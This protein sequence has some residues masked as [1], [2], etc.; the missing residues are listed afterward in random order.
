MKRKVYRCSCFDMSGRYY[1]WEKHSWNS[2]M[3]SL[4]DYVRGVAREGEIWSEVAKSWAKD[5]RQHVGGSSSWKS[6]KGGSLVFS[7]TL[8]K[9]D[10][11]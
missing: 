6:D 8:M 9:G 2:A 7:V 1:S 5:G 11:E 4:V 10:V 3:R